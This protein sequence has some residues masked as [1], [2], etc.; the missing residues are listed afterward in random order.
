MFIAKIYALI[1]VLVIAAAVALYF[2]G[3][4]G[5]T[6]LVALAF[7]VAGLTG[8]WL[9]V[10]LPSVLHEDVREGRNTGG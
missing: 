10:V 4:L 5:Q 1:W 7:A 8:A 6:Q 3:A 2:A 9:L